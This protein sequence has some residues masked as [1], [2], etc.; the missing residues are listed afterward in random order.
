MGLAA[1]GRRVHDPRMAGDPFPRPVRPIE[2]E[3]VV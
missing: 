1:A 2:R 3:L